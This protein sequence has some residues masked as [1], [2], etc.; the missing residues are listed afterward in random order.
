MIQYPLC[1][2]L[3]CKMACF[4][5][6]SDERIIF[7]KRRGVAKDLAM[8]RQIRSKHFQV[9]TVSKKFTGNC[10]IYLLSFRFFVIITTNILSLRFSNLIEVFHR[11]WNVQNYSQLFM[12]EHRTRICNFDTFSQY[13]CRRLKIKRRRTILFF[14]QQFHF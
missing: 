8:N 12:H 10:R 11:V 2:L 14:D 9:H 7:D 6:N 5:K 3:L 1:Q 13:F 4:K